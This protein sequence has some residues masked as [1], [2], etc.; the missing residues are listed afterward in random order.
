MGI[1]SKDLNNLDLNTQDLNNFLLPKKTRRSEMDIPVCIFLVLI[2]EIIFR[3][4]LPGNFKL[5]RTICP[6]VFMR[7]V[8][9]DGSKTCFSAKHD[10]V[11]ECRPQA[12]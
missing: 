6:L 1:I 9:K 11:C 3:Y 7:V 12:S 4:I 10:Q 8:F 2:P 5:T